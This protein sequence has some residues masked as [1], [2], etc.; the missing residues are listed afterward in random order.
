MWQVDTFGGMCGIWPGLCAPDKWQRHFV[1][2]FIDAGAHIS[3]YVSVDPV[4]GGLVS[5][6][7]WTKHFTSALISRDR[8]ISLITNA[9]SNGN[10]NRSQTM[11]RSRIKL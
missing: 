5:S 10:R 3:L 8:N 4:N 2:E 9:K 7:I 1:G 6:T 11:R